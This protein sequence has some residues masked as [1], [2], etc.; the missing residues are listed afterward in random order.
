MGKL[1]KTVKDLVLNDIVGTT[2]WHGETNADNDSLNNM[3]AS[4]E[5]ALALLAN[6]KDNAM[7]SDYAVQTASGERLNNRAKDM[8]KDIKEEADLEF[9]L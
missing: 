8:L 4:Y 2:I 6:I 3:E 7:L 1:N 5:L 9:T